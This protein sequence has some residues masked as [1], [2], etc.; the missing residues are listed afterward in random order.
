MSF[1]LPSP[2]NLSTLSRTLL[3]TLPSLSVPRCGHV[4]CPE[5]CRI[6]FRGCP[7]VC[8]RRK[9]RPTRHRF[10]FLVAAVFEAR[11]TRAPSN[12]PAS[13]IRVHRTRQHPFVYRGPFCY[14]L[15]VSESS[16][17]PHI[18][19]AASYPA[20]HPIAKAAFS[21]GSLPVTGDHEPRCQVCR[22]AHRCIAS[23][24]HWHRSRLV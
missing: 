15:P 21:S 13:S 3:S 10:L 7:G 19:S 24:T 4:Y 18:A 1:D 17:W 20:P 22:Q 11:A 5:S 23:D 8:S 12:S 9:E 2:A 6:G 16:I 14:Q